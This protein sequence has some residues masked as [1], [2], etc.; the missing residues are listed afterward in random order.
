M[1][2]FK[3]DDIV[4]LSAVRSQRNKG[5]GPRVLAVGDVTGW[6]RSNRAFPQSQSVA[7]ADFY[8]I[9]AALL[10]MIRP[11]FVLSPAICAQFD[12]LDLAAVLHAAGFKGMFRALTGQLPAPDI[13]RRE[14]AACYPGLD[15]DF[16]DSARLAPM[17]TV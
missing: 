8:E 1:F 15:F 14:V 4:D 16:L 5:L 12:C 10:D 6:R 3:D 9:D 2:C 7:L 17:M 11:E 13:I